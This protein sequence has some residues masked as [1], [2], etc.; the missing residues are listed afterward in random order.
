MY[1]PYPARPTLRLGIDLQ[2]VKARHEERA[3][4]ERQMQ[5]LSLRWTELSMLIESEH[6]QSQPIRASAP[7]SDNDF[8]T[9]RHCALIQ[10]A[11]SGEIRDPAE[12][13]RSR[14]TIR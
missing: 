13:L 10:A 1:D 4:I 7:H 11:A 3:D 14:R 6:A 5:A 8:W 9:H 12:S 2:A